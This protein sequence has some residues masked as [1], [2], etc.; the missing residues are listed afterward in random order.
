MSDTVR[1]LECNLDDMTGE[2]LGY[3]MERT[4]TEGA[5]DTWFTPIYMKKN[6]PAVMLSVLC[7]PDDGPKLTR[8]LFEHTST[9]GVRWKDMDR[10]ICQRSTVVAEIP[11][12]SIRC[13]LKSLNGTAMALKPEY[14]DCAAVAR[15]HNLRLSEVIE[16]ARTAGRDPLGRASK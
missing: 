9:L 16:A 15:A 7:R 10:E 1:L 5:L 11:W 4:L 2:E 13:K 12:G 8:V 14:E 6:R 3:A